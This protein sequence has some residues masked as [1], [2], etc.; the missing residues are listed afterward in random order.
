MVVFIFVEQAIS[1]V[2]MAIPF[3]GQAFSGGGLA[4]VF[5]EAK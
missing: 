5:R 1:A 3:C 4:G 2:R